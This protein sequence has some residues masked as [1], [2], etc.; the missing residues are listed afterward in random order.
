[1]SS[2]L[3]DHSAW[4]IVR[5]DPLSGELITTEEEAYRQQIREE[6]A[7]G[8]VGVDAL[9]LS[10]QQ[11]LHQPLVGEQGTVS[12]D[13]WLLK[14]ANRTTLRVPVPDAGDP[15]AL[16]EAA[17]TIARAAI[18]DFAAEVMLQLFAVAND[19]P[20]W[21]RAEF[22]IRLSDLLDRLGFKRDNRG[23]HRSDARRRLATTLLALHLTHVGVQRNAQRRG[24]RA[25]GFIAP[26]L[27]SVG[28]ATQEDVSHLS[29]IEVFEQGLPEQV[30]VSINPVW[31]EGLRRRD[32]A[33]GA[34][35]ALIPRATPRLSAGRPRRGRRSTVVD[36][37]REYLLRCQTATGERQ[38]TVSR[39]ALLEI[40]S[41]HDRNPRQAGRT[42]TKAL[43]ALRSEGVV[44][45]FKPEPL[46]LGDVDLVTIELIPA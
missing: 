25:M 7:Q 10:V 44:G 15:T 41:I 32:G 46:P 34:D 42:L 24:G 18:D 36:L 2:E 30:A 16:E 27:S 26:L 29:P 45:A 9:Y 40:A 14:R 6:A 33:A 8:L 22:S 11:A 35:Y 43:E 39:Q 38:V 37:L 20:N 21:R 4:T 31:Y 28:Y 1:M 13:A 23:V 5:I 3:P 12:G 19:P 17:I